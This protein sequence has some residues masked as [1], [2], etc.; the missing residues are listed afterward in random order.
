MLIVS[1]MF[2]FMFVFMFIFVVIVVIV[3]T[4]FPFMS[5]MPFAMKGD[6]IKA[7]VARIGNTDMSPIADF[8]NTK[9]HGFFAVVRIG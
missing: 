8:G 4:R 2:V 7:F 1:F 5:T 6:A 3:V 9:T